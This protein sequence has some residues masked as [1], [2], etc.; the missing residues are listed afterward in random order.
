MK[1]KSFAVLGLG[2]YGSSL[3][4][5]L[6]DLGMDVLVCDRNEDRVRDFENRSTVA[7]TC[8]L[9]DEEA[10]YSLGFENMDVVIVT[11][12]TDLAASILSVAVAK[13]KGVPLVI[14]KAATKHMG[15]ILK[16]VGA[17][18]IV[19]PET[20]S[21]LRLARVLASSG[22]L[23]FFADDDNLC[24]VEMEP[25]ETWIGKSLE[26]LDLRRHLGANIIAVRTEKSKWAFPDASSPL[27]A[28]CRLLVAVERKTLPFLQ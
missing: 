4:G 21:G 12:S 2:K 15:A 16:R 19:E 27:S 17:D 3:A 5:G 1:K 23:D 11:T 7:V 14:A 24:I 25:K 10:L 6:F 9:A 22:I 18:R 8:E 20:E 26:S 28:D 13:E